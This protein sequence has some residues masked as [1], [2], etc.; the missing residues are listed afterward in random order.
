MIVNV[1]IYSLKGTANYLRG[2]E[3]YALFVQCRISI[4]SDRFLLSLHKETVC[5]RVK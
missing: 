3:D 1:A 4:F 2:H 5:Q